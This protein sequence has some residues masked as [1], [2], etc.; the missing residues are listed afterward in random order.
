MNIIF[1]YNFAINTTAT[2]FDFVCVIF[3][4]CAMMFFIAIS[5]RGCVILYIYKNHSVR[6]T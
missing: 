6:N 1:I 4:V 2:C 5:F 3:V